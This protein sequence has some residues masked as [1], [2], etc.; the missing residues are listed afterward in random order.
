MEPADYFLHP[1]IPS[2]KHYEALRTFY[3]EKLN[4]TEVAQLFSFSP[5]YFKKLRFSFAGQ[6][7][8]G[9][10]PFFQEKKRGPKSRFTKPEVVEKIVA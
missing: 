6:I 4:A 2:Q 1:S 7:K 3:V 5:S 9:N 10:N 8:E